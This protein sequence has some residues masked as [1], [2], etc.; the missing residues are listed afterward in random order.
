VKSVIFSQVFSL[1]LLLSLLI[2]LKLKS[3]LLSVV[4]F[5][6]GVTGV[7]TQG[8]MIARQALHQLIDTPSPPSSLWSLFSMAKMRP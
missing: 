4:V 7:L 1:L 5:V 2:T 6:F 8:F 3:H